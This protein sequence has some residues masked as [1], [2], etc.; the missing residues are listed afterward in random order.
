MSTAKVPQLVVSQPI[1]LDDG[2]MSQIFRTWAQMMTTYAAPIVG[3]GSPENVI[4][5]PQ[6]SLYLDR[7]GVPGALQYRKMQ[8]HIGGNKKLGWVAV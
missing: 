2:T 7:L 8:P 5:A 6:Y 3:D 4:E 1:V